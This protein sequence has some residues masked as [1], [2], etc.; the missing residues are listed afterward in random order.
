MKNLVHDKIIP[1]TNV[2]YSGPP[3]I[4]N[5]YD[6]FSENYDKFVNWDS[7]LKSELPFLEAHIGPPEKTTHVLDSACGTGMHAIALA[8]KG[9]HVSGADLS[10][11]MVVK[12]RANA[13]SANQMVR[14]EQAGFGELSKTFGI[15][16]FDTILCLGNSLPHILNAHSLLVALNDFASCLRPGGLVIIQNRNFDSVMARKERWQEPQAYQE[17]EREWIFL[18]FYDYLAD[19]NIDFNIVTLRREGHGGWKQET[20]STRLWPI[21]Q[22]ELTMALTNA[23]FEAIQAYGDLSGTAFD[24]LKSGNLVITARIKGVSND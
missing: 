20:T 6:H 12:A 21:L 19:G 2:L 10:A 9:Y 1:V 3:M 23:E 13:G 16:S 24:R 11:G 17:Q 4:D 5:A 22:A 7:R 8:Q 14:F 18:R 15:A